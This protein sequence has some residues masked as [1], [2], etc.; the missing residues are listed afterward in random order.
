MSCLGTV[1]LVDASLVD[2]FV[3]HMENIGFVSTET[4]SK[5][6]RAVL[7]REVNASHRV[8]VF[9]NAKG[10]ITITCNGVQPREVME[11]FN[12]KFTIKPARVV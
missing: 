2:E 5:Y 8:T 6:E 12:G 4:N 9:C 10:R 7:Q 11:G 3:K 1:F